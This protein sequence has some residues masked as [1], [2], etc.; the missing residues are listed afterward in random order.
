LVKHGLYFDYGDYVQI[1]HTKKLGF[2]STQIAILG[3]FKLA[4]KTQFGQMIFAEGPFNRVFISSYGKLSFS[5]DI[6][7][8]YPYEVISEVTIETDEWYRFK[9]IYKVDG[10]SS[11]IFL[12]INGRLTGS[13]S[14]SGQYQ[15][16][17][18]T[19]DVT[20]GCNSDHTA[21][22]FNGVLNYIKVENSR[23]CIMHMPS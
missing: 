16:Q 21:F 9:A 20:L 11:D 23:H 14:L 22:F 5:V 7:T 6:G 4:S 15:I 2:L 3:K 19:H 18:G 1:S 8:I 17:F 13:C 12:Y 10:D